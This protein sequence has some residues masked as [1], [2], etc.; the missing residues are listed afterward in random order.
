MIIEN[1]LNHKSLICTSDNLIRPQGPT[2]DPVVFICSPLFQGILV[3]NE[4]DTKKP[5]M[6]SE[7]TFRNMNRLALKQ[8]LHTGRV[9][10]PT[11][12]QKLF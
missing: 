10:H 11:I 2:T 7:L 6:V 1:P 5:V 9:S 3:L 4:V 12:W 8:T